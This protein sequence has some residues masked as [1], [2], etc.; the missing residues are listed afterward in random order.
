LIT[1]ENAGLPTGDTVS[2]I[3]V[4]PAADQISQN[5][6]ARKVTINVRAGSTSTNETIVTY[7]NKVPPAQLKVCKVAG[8]PSLVGDLFSF[9]ENGGSPFSVA[10]GTPSAPNCSSLQTYQVGTNVN[11]AELPTAGTMVSSIAVSPATEASNTSTANGTVTVTLQPGVTVVT[12]T[13]VPVSPT[14]TG[15]LEV[16]KL[17]SDQY[18]TGSFQFTITAAGGFSETASVA[19]GQCTQALTV[20]AGNVT[21]T[22]TQRAPY[23]LDDVFTVPYNDLVSQNDANGTAVVNVVQSNSAETQVNFVNDTQTAEVK[24][25][26][27][28]TANST[29][30]AGQTF[31]FD[32]NSAD[33]ASREAVVAG[34]AGSTVCQL[35]TDQFGDIEFLP[36]GSSVSITE[37]SQPF[38]LNTSV[39]V[40][41]S[42]Q[43]AGSAPPTAN[44]IVGTGVT[45]ATFTNQAEGQIELCKQ[46]TQYAPTNES[47]PMTITDGSVVIKTSVPANSCTQ[48]ITVPAGTATVTETELPN[49]VLQSISV[50]GS[51]TEVSS[52]GTS[53]TVTVPFAGDTTVTFTNTVATGQF[54]ICKVSAEP[55]LQGIAFNFTWSYTANG[56]LFTGA[57]NVMPGQCSLVH[58][59]IPVIDPNGNPT[60]I[61][62][63]ETATGYSQVSSITVS[64]GSVV[65][66][67]LTAQSEVFT[68]LPNPTGGT[69]SVTFTNVRTPVGPVAG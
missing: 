42:A 44:L 52:S 3:K 6:G 28:L 69:T 58:G 20:P 10:A 66:S 4:S 37:E 19:V 17:A 15:L 35:V 8:D 43:D 13:N 68:L 32:I 18:V 56:T 25:C 54:K 60:Q 59:P 65:S 33:G 29:A 46:V 61:T 51:G 67:N 41:P 45:Q 31:W 63:T 22:E 12:Y 1:E 2:A 9:T 47:F 38:V 21:V 11:I 7:T 16:C 23:F 39:V 50:S 49:F 55:T 64:N 26:K 30:L 40:S 36:V 48:P 34:S 14:Q 62:V 24:V 5:L 53:V 57:D 27:T